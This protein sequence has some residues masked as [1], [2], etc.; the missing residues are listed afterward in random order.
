M[1]RCD[2]DSRLLFVFSTARIVVERFKRSVIID[3]VTRSRDPAPAATLQTPDALRLTHEHVADRAHHDRLRR[4]GL[5]NQ[6][7]ARIDEHADALRNSISVETKS[8][9]CLMM[10]MGS[11]EDPVLTRCAC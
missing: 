8:R 2:Y 7:N 5:W 11:L 3:I 10:F 6:S 1:L 4:T 9:I